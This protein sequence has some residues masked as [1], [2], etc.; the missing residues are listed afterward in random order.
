M[1]VSGGIYGLRNPCVKMEVRGN[2]DLIQLRTAFAQAAHLPMR[3][4]LAFVIRVE[5]A[6]A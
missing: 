6:A 5:G 1:R 3:G 2:G 4:P